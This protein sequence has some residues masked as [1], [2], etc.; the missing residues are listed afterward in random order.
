[1]SHEHTDKKTKVAEVLAETMAHFISQQSNRTSLI[2]VSHV[3]VVSRGTKAI[4]HITVLPDHAGDAAIDFLNRNIPDARAFIRKHVKIGR[5]PMIEY[6]LDDG[7]KV[8][9]VLK[10]Q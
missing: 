10:I 2:T 1:M 9:N 7:A 6:R 4:V 8:H 3:E 5:V